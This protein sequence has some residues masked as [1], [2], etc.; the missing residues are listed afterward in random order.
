MQCVSYES[1]GKLIEV[2]GRNALKCCVVHRKEV[3]DGKD[4]QFFMHMYLSHPFFNSH[5][6]LPL[7]LMSERQQKRSLEVVND[8]DNDVLLRMNRFSS[9]GNPTSLNT[10][11]LK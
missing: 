11:Y 10:L 9:S 3:E 5:K 4:F 7:R 1:Y 8:F 6:T 2:I